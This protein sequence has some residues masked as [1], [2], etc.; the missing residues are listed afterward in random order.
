VQDMGIRLCQSLRILG[1][2]VQRGH[3]HLL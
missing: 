3:A 2:I 1:C